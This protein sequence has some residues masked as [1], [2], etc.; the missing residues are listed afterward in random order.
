VC[1]VEHGVVGGVRWAGPGKGEL[2]MVWMDV[3]DG[4]DG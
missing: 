4:V 2:R 3:A 1:G